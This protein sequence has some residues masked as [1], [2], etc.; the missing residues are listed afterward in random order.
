MKFLFSQIVNNSEMPV[1]IENPEIKN[2]AVY[3]TLVGKLCGY[4]WN[5]KP[6]FKACKP[7]KFV[8]GGCPWKMIEYNEEL[9]G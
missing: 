1:I 2:G 5:D 3:A 4:T 8:A 7:A 9:E 6:R